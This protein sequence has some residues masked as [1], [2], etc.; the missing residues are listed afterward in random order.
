MNSSNGSQP[1]AA[2]MRSR[3]TRETARECASSSADIAGSIEGEPDAFITRPHGRKTKPSAQEREAIAQV[4]S[5][6]WPEGTA[7]AALHSE[8]PAAAR[9]SRADHG[10]GTTRGRD[11]RAH[12]AGCWRERDDPLPQVRSR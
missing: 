3:M 11:D 7:P 5:P 10:R 2:S 8:Q 4:E 6:R 1:P 12:A 9:E